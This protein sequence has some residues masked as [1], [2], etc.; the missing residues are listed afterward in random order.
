MTTSRSVPVDD[1]RGWLVP[2]VLL[3]VA[4]A[5]IGGHFSGYAHG[6]DLQLLVAAV[7]VVP[8]AVVALALWA[9]LA[10]VT[11]PVWQSVLLG[12]ATCVKAFTVFAI[13]WSVTHPTGFGPHGVLDWLPIGAANA[14][15][16]LLLLTFIRSRRTRRR[17]GAQ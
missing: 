4:L 3:L 5:W 7:H 13:V 9:C 6:V 14:G 12:V 16:G 10:G 17:V 15:S 11:E 1:D 2:G 8:V